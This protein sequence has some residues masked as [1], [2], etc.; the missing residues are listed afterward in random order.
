VNNIEIRTGSGWRE[1]G[2]R[3]AAQKG[4]RTYNGVPLEMLVDEPKGSDRG[5]DSEET[6]YNPPHIMR[7]KIFESNQFCERTR[8]DMTTTTYLEIPPCRVEREKV[9][10]QVPLA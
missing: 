7:Y 2:G 6:G 5:Y 9:P 1:R 3:E 4:K 10:F 8:A